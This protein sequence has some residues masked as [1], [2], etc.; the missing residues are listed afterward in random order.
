MAYT[1]NLGF[2]RGNA[3]TNVA[4]VTSDGSFVE[5][6]AS[7]IIAEAN[8]SRMHT[9]NAGASNTN[10]NT[11]D[12]MVLEYENGQYIFGD[13]ALRN[14]VNP[15]TGFG[16]TNRYHGPHTKRALL[17]YTSQIAA[18]LSN[19]KYGVPSELV[20]NLVMGVPVNVYKQEAQLIRSQLEG[21]VFKY[22]FNDREMGLHIQMTR[23]F[24]EGAGAAITKGL[25]TTGLTGV[26][27]T[28]SFTT[29]ILVFDG[30]KPV[31][32]L[33]H[34]FEVGIGSALKRVSD[35]FENKYDRPLDDGERESLLRSVLGFENRPEIYVD[36]QLVS[37]IDLAQWMGD[38][39]K[40]TAN[41]IQ[42]RVRSIWKNEA[43]KFKTI[44][45]VGGGS[46]YLHTF[47]DYKQAIKP[48]DPERYNSRGYAILAQQLAQRADTSKVHLVKKGA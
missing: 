24:M 10:G 13:F 46:L 19:A 14:G 44:L 27:D 7:S 32:E 43:R 39:L 20:L 35:R 48:N 21:Q 33:C 45:H 29:N 31:P 38:A 16:D 5:I 36:G 4:T 30:M 47:L 41:D 18:L 17:A 11:F 15:T 25:D 2:D 37:Q 12:N 3:R 1:L 28:G 22:R 26:I 40:E 42:T 23:V 8:L 9:I 6:D 34:S